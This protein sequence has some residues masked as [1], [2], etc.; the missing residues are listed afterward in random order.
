MINFKRIFCNFD[1]PLFTI[2]THNSPARKL[3]KHALIKNNP[4]WQNFKTTWTDTIIQKL[5]DLM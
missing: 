4:D 2:V 5:V 3:Q 1:N